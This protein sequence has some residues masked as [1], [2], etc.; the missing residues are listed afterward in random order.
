[1]VGWKSQQDFGHKGTYINVHVHVVGTYINVLV[2][3]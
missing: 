3:D 1:M 2:V